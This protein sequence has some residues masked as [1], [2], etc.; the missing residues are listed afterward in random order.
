[1][2]DKM[3]DNMKEKTGKKLDQWIAIIA[4]EKFEKHG[5]II[6]FLK[7]E[8]G[9]THG[10]ANLVALKY[11]RSDAGSS[12]PMDL[13]RGQYK[14]KEDLFGLYERIVADLKTFAPEAEIAPKKAYVS[15]RRK[16]QFGLIQPST[17]KRLDL[18]LVLKD[19]EPQG[20]LE[21]SG[22]FNS[23]CTHRIRLETPSDIDA[24]VM[25]WLREAYKQAS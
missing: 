12:D 10:Y 20:K 8:H 19:T 23:M 18:G 16:K 17:K 21:K 2:E 22:S 13:I 4:R 6:K 3:I 7:S 14:G 5:E 15:L 1:M 25:N 11:R 24:D 9:M